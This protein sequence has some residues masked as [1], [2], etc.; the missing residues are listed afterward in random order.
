MG[1]DDLSKEFDSG[2]SGFARS[3]VSVGTFHGEPPP[4]RWLVPNWVPEGEVCSLYGKGGVG[5]SLVVLQLAYS[6]ALGEPWLGLETVQ[7]STLYVS[8]EDDRAELE[9]RHAA[10][11]TGLGHSIGNPF[12]GVNVWPRRGENNLLAC[13][14][15]KGGLIAGPF[16]AELRD[17]VELLNPALLI[18]DTLADVFGGAEIDRV[19][20][21][22]FLKTLVGGLIL[23]RR[24]QGHTLT[25]MLLGHPSK[26]GM[27]DESGLSGSTAWD[28]SVRA[29][30]YLRRPENAGPDERVLTRAKA[31]Y[32]SGDGDEL[33][34]LYSAGVFVGLDPNAA[35]VERVALTVRNE[36]QAAWNAGLQY[37]EK[38]GH[39]RELHGSLTRK[40]TM[41][42]QPRELVQAGLRAAIDDGL[43][44]PCRTTKKRGWR[45]RDDE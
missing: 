13:Q 37:V 19:Q 14:D 3:W 44:Y 8:C 38:K 36:V 6:M 33:A 41:P 5:K 27:A 40:L 39:P 43:I 24:A 42:N 16:M 1:A 45:G 12:G 25:V 11:R 23:E 26:A 18:L 15:G 10:I 9:R 31:N 22:F 28:N 4:R 7:G 29:R 30:L 32:S 35:L 20:V 34:L 17:G 21:N 2:S